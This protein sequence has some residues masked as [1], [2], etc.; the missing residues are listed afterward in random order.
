[1]QARDAP[2]V[3]EEVHR[4]VRRQLLEHEAV[5]EHREAG[6]AGFGREPR[7]GQPMLREHAEHFEKGLAGH[8]AALVVTIDD[9][10]EA[11]LDRTAH[12]L[13]DRLLLGGKHQVHA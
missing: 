2:F 1:V 8:C 13:A 7:R 6:A 4:D 3:R 11:A 12:R 10:L 5:I 9:R